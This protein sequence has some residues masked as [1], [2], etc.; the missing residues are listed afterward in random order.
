MI[1]AADPGVS[2]TFG[3]PAVK[4]GDMFHDQAA[5][6][7]HVFMLYLIPSFLSRSSGHSLDYSSFPRCC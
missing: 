1:F 7:V 2:P 6:P 4:V 5:F 3:T